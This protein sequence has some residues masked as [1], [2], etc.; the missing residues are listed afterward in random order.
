LGGGNHERV[1]RIEESLKETHG[2]NCW[3][4]KSQMKGGDF[5]KKMMEGIDRS[6]VVVVFVTKTYISKVTKGSSADNC[7]VEFDYAV[8]TRTNKRM[9][10][11]VMEP[12]AKK[13]SE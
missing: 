6:A 2:L 5:R 9:I 10:F 8:A 13:A 3:I 1:I 7:K 12:T 11:V 4:D